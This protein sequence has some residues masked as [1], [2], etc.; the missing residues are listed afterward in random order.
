MPLK[1]DFVRPQAS[2]K[3]GV[4]EE[5]RISDRRSNV[6]GIGMEIVYL[7]V[8]ASVEISRRQACRIPLRAAPQA[9]IRR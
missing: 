2:R 6:M 3:R 1:A 9:V 8:V 7:G 4:A 5:H